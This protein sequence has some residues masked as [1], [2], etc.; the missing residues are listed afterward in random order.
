MPEQRGHM[1]ILIVNTDYAAFTRQL[2]AANAGLAARPYDEQFS[3]LFNSYYEAIGDRHP[4]VE[5][6]LVS[7]PSADEVA[8]PPA[9][10]APFVPNS[11]NCGIRYV[12]ALVFTVSP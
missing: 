7:R 3:Y 6:G 10:T 5:R 9:I 2:Y 4:R 12:K 8:L 11:R 1:R